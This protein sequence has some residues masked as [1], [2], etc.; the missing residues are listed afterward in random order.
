MSST[1]FGYPTLYCVKSYFPNIQNMIARFTHFF[2]FF[3]KKRWSVFGIG[4]SIPVFGRKDIR[5]RN[6]SEANRITFFCCSYL[7]S[8]YNYFEKRALLEIA[9]H[10]ENLKI[11]W[12]F[13]PRP[14]LEMKHD[15]KWS[16]TISHNRLWLA[17]KAYRHFFCWVN[18]TLSCKV[19]LT[20]TILMNGWLQMMSTQSESVESSAGSLKR[21]ATS[22][23]KELEV[24][25]ADDLGVATVEVIGA[26]DT[27]KSSRM[28]V[29]SFNG[30]YIILVD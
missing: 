18:H 29:G 6:R 17:Q 22:P 26:D 24:V 8:L 2:L 30:F 15:M 25:T 23:P 21:K 9:N 13:Q 5:V 14:T 10:S 16:K 1:Q 4:E 20:V 19:W 12:I 7:C 28:K 3:L 11:T 27:N